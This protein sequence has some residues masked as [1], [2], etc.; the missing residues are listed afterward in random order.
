MKAIGY[1]QAHALTDLPAATNT[2]L[3]DITLPDPTPAG[4]DLL[5][6]VMA[7]SVNPV[8]TKVRALRDSVKELKKEYDKT[9]DD[10]KALQSVGQIIGE[11]LKQLDE[12]RCKTF[13]A[14]N[15]I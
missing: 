4:H 8:D 9:E 1:T 2:G 3:Q 7:I 10:L 11:V 5:V 15:A 13:R 6:E 14:Q 12:E